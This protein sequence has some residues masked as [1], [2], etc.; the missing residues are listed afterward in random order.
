MRRTKIIATL[1]PAT[2]DPET[3]GKLIAAGADVVRVNFSHGGTGDRERRVRMVRQVAEQMGKYVA[4]LGD[5][6]G[7]KIRIQRFRDGSVQLVEGQGFILDPALDAQAGTVEEIGRASC[8][9]RVYSS[10]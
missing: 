3:L 9:E 2:D 5:L 1:G 8:R 4:I 6:Q 10:V 7:P